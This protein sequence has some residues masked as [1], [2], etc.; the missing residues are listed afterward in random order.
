MLA[1][2]EVTFDLRP[3]SLP[4][5]DPKLD[6]AAALASLQCSAAAQLFLARARAA[7]S[8]Y[9]PGHQDAVA[10]AT[11][12]R[13]LDGLPLAIEL[14]ASRVRTLE[15]LQLLERL[16][17]RMEFS[18]KQSHT[19]SALRG[20]I[21]WSWEL[22]SEA[23]KGLL[24]QSS[25]FQSGFSLDAAEQVLG[26]PGLDVL[27]V[28]QDLSD[29][30]LIYSY[31][32]VG[33]VE[34]RYGLYAS[35][36]EFAQT[37]LEKSNAMEDAKRRHAEFYSAKAFDWGDRSYGRD[38]NA[39]LGM[40]SLEQA[41][42]E[43]AHRWACTQVPTTSTAEIAIRAAVGLDPLLCTRGPLELQARLGEEAEAV[44][45]GLHV[46]PKLAGR[47]AVASGSAHLRR[48]LHQQARDEFSEASRMAEAIGDADLYARAATMLAQ[49]AHSQGQVAQARA[50]LQ[51]A[52][53]TSRRENLPI[54]EGRAL[55][56]LS[57]CI[58]DS[59]TACELLG[60]AATILFAA[61][62]AN[63]AATALANLGLKK[64]ATGHLHAAR[65]YFLESLET[66]RVDKDGRAESFVLR[67]LATI[68]EELGDVALAQLRH[69]EGL[70]VLRALGDVTEQG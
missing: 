11:L 48:G 33:G 26:S 35:I 12:V 58:G 65:R 42:I 22:L 43:A 46:S 51:Q 56:G 59:G 52:L 54:R 38:R 66:F 49:H 30:S 19:Y 47:L 69:E 67:H 5:F 8:E 1:E 25:V 34:R 55:I 61:G 40:L 7:R 14:A 3:L 23:E 44:T 6:A 21:A 29:Q 60:E 4:V 62:D 39:L 28:L 2:S 70:A 13:H 16:T 18:D 63:S 17:N 9:Q 10:I 41:N 31:K 45:R 20:A 27:D 15:P 57:Q 53:D 37:Q 36:R 64:L 68:D 50:F 24:A 32:P